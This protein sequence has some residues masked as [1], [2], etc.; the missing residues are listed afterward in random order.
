MAGNG[1]HEATAYKSVR[2]PPETL[3]WGVLSLLS[4]DWYL[5]VLA[6]MAGTGPQDVEHTKEAEQHHEEDVKGHVEP[7]TADWRM[8][9]AV[10]DRW[11]S[12]RTNPKLILIALFAS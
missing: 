1:F 12:I 4:F 8:E 7:V 9:S 3:T 5:E 2:N 10:K 6:N 11:H